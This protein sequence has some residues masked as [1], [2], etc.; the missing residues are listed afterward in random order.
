MRSGHILVFAIAASLLTQQSLNAQVFYSV[1]LD[2]D[3]LVTVNGITGDVR[4]IGSLGVDFNETDIDVN[5]AIFN[6]D[7]YAVVDF[8]DIAESHLYRIN[9][10]SGQASHLSQLTVFGTPITHSEGVYATETGLRVSWTTGGLSTSTDL[11]NLS[12]GGEITSTVSTGV[13]MDGLAIDSLGQL[14]SIDARGT[15]NQVLVYELEPTLHIGTYPAL[16]SFFAEDL[17]M[18]NDRL[19]AMSTGGILEIDKSNGS[20]ISVQALSSMGNFK[21]IATIPEPTSLSTALGIFAVLVT[22]GRRRFKS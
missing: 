21:G 13:D 7:L 15:Q 11:G 17:T 19:F 20:L 22:T 9:R 14:Y 4:S 2:T 6:G 18:W 1:N 10:S 3:E 16:G 12:I 5:L 8:Q